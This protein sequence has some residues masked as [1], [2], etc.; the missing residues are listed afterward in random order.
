MDADRFYRRM[1]KIAKENSDGDERL[2][3]IR[4]AFV[5]GL[6]LLPGE[7][8]IDLFWETAEYL[9]LRELSGREEFLETAVT[10]TQVVELFRQEFGAT[11]GEFPEE[12][13]EIIR[14]CVNDYATELDEDLLNYLMGLVLDYGKI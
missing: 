12:L 5:E 8:G 4:D 10:L 11:E 1:L 6:P 14:D 9:N 13:W 7:M 3:R 2:D